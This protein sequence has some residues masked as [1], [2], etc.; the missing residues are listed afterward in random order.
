[1]FA[2]VLACLLACVCVCLFACLLACLLPSFLTSLLVGFCLLVGWF[3]SLLLSLVGFSLDSLPSEP[4]DISQKDARTLEFAP[5]K[6]CLINWGSGNKSHPLLASVWGLFK[7]PWGAKRIELSTLCLS[8]LAPLFVMAQGLRMVSSSLG[9]VSSN[10]FWR[11]TSGS[12]RPQVQ[13]LISI[14]GENCT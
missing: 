2:C 3:P 7:N 8:C 1:M 13:M 9:Q 4:F 11:G 10:V 14:G 5:R 12:D 6:G